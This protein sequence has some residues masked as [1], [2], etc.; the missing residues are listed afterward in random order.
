LPQPMADLR[1]R[2]AVIDDHVHEV[3]SDNSYASCDDPAR[4]QKSA[5][6]IDLAQKRNR[7]PSNHAR[8]PSSCA[9]LL[10]GRDMDWAYC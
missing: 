9:V 10:R 4:T 8:C 2:L 3:S 1:G 6:R 7:A 5:R